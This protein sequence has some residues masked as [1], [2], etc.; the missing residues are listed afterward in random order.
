MDIVA[1]LKLL[2]MGT[3]ACDEFGFPQIYGKY[4]LA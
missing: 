4:A 1:R 2:I 3:S